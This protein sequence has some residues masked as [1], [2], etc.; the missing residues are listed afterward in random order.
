MVAL[1]TPLRSRE[2]VRQV[3]YETGHH[4]AAGRRERVVDERRHEAVDPEL[5]GDPAAAR[6]TIGGLRAVEPGHERELRA[7]KRVGARLLGLEPRLLRQ[8]EIELAAGAVH[9][10]AA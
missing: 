10:D 7:A 4:V 3:L 5:F 2:P 8:H 9:L 6:F 1:K